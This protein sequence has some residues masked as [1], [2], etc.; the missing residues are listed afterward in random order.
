[1]P[2]GSADAPT[3]APVRSPI[4]H[5]PPSGNDRT[6]G[7][8]PRGR[9][10]MRRGRNGPAGRGGQRGSRADGDCHSSV[11]WLPSSARVTSSTAAVGVSLAN[12]GPVHGVDNRTGRSPDPAPTPPSPARRPRPC[13]GPE[14]RHR[15][16]RARPGGRTRRPHTG[17]PLRRG[18]RSAHAEAEMSIAIT[19]GR[20]QQRL[21]FP[22]LV[23]GTRGLVH[24]TRTGPS[25]PTRSAVGRTGRR[26]RLSQARDQSGVHTDVADLLCASRIAEWL[27][28]AGQRQLEEREGVFQMDV[29]RL[30]LAGDPVDGDR[31]PGT[32]PHRRR[33]RSVGLM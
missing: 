28:A 22:E 18:Q 30:V 24:S 31:R 16:P 20:R 2:N 33:S 6:P 9:R 5:G 26:R 23:V 17:H 14:P 8:P 7:G 19:G 3:T 32:P 13:D 25:P 15:P 11:R 12:S 1:M 10:R 27:A 29:Q 21:H 4:R